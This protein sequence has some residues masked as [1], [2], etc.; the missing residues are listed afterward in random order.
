MV[1]TA[2]DV[3]DTFEE[4]FATQTAST[5]QQLAAKLCFD[6]PLTEKDS[7]GDKSPHFAVP[8]HERPLSSAIALQECAKAPHGS[9]LRSL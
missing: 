1:G 4:L 5:G 8:R 9:C 2:I 7:T 6:L 3:T